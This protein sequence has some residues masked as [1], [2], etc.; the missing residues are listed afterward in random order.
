[1]AIKFEKVKAGMH[2]YDVHSYRMGNTIQRAHR[3][4]QSAPSK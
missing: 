3:A 2:L 1:M 4:I